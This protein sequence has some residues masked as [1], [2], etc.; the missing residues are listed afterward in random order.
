MNSFSPGL[1]ALSLTFTAG[2]AAGLA[3]PVGAGYY[4]SGALALVLPGLTAMARYVSREDGRT[5]LP[6]LPLCFLAGFLSGFCS[7]VLFELN[8]ALKHLQL[9]LCPHLMQQQVFQ[10]LQ[11]RRQKNLLSIQAA[12]YLL[13]PTLYCLYQ[14][15]LEHL[16]QF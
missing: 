16:V 1:M 11:V 14:E 8:K 13:Y 9:F 3:F 10:F 5:L 15:H 12:F 6:L 7:R 2:A 4:A